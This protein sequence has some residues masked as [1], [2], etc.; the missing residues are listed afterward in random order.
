[1]YLTRYVTVQNK[2]ILYIVG[3]LP[4]HQAA[5]GGH[6]SVVKFLV[7]AGT[8]VDATKTYQDRH[9]ITSLHLAAENGCDKTVKILLDLGAAKNAADSSGFTAMHLAARE[10]QRTTL[11]ILIKSG[12]E[13]H[14]CATH[15]GD[16]LENITPLHLAAK[17][18]HK[19]IVNDLLQHHCNVNVEHIS[20]GISG[21]T[22]LHVVS[23]EGHTSIARLLIK[24]GADP[25]LMTSAGKTPLDLAIE[26]DYRDVARV[27]KRV[28]I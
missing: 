6:V 21:I 16:A 20:G 15:Y 4:L 17:Y 10:G 18:G 28:T 3:I 8:A 13:T 27:L 22:P 5:H 19:R 9:G 2:T 25:L 12:A 24:A 23:I 1:M 14:C 26:N 7:A 11:E